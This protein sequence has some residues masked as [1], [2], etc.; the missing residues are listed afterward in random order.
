MAK[1]E[2]VIINED[3]NLMEIDN[4]LDESYGK[5][6]VLS[7]YSDYDSECSEKFTEGIQSRILYR[8]VIIT[9]DIMKKCVVYIFIIL[10]A[11]RSFACCYL[12]KSDLIS[13]ILATRI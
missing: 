9:I 5:N 2:A 6:R 10:L 1:E 13:H 12:R 8:A 11:I 4:N 3:D 7:E